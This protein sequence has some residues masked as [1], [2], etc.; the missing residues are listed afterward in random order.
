MDEDMSFQ[1]M[2]TNPVLTTNTKLMYDGS[3]MWME[4]FDASTQL[5]S[6]R[7]KNYQVYQNGY[8]NEDLK[9]FLTGLG[10]TAYVVGQKWM[11]M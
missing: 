3:S 5:T 4:S 1:L 7:Y 11:I 9:K 8:Y 6:Q 10:N 2:R